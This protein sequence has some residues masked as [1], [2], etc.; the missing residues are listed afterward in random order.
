[1][2]CRVEPVEAYWRSCAVLV[3]GCDSV[4][5]RMVSNCLKLKCIS[6]SACQPSV[7]NVT[8]NICH[9]AE[10]APAVISTHH[11][12]ALF[13]ESTSQ[14]QLIILSHLVKDHLFSCLP[15]ATSKLCVSS[16]ALPT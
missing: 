11:S 4:F 5:A 7:G 8:W 13:K 3:Q 15:R 2:L 9:V 6:H 14:K 16:S 1:M 10:T 12:T